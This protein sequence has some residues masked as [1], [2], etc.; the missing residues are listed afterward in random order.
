MTEKES[1]ALC[2]TDDVQAALARVAESAD[3][4]VVKLGSKGSLVW[5]EG[6]TYTAG[7]HP[8]DA[9]DTTGAGDAY[10]A[11]FLYGYVSGW[12][13][14]HSADLGSRVAAE[15]VAQV[16]AVVRNS[17]LLQSLIEKARP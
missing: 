17:E 15:T 2:E 14:T 12:S 6:R 10:A 5:H 4:V 8:V 16:G 11:G 9:I 13:P 7:V 1:A 3:T